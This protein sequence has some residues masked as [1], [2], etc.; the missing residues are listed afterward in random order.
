M[1][2]LDI[3][4]AASSDDC[5]AYDPGGY[6][7]LT[8]SFWLAYAFE[9]YQCDGAR[10][11]VVNIPQ[12]ATIIEAHVTGSAGGADGS[13]DPTCR[14]KAQAADNAATFSTRLD[15]DGR[16]RTTAYV[17][18]VIPPL[19]PGVDYDTPDLASLIQEVVARPGWMA[20]NGL[21]LFFDDQTLASYRVVQSYDDGPPHPPILHIEYLPPSLIVDPVSE[22]LLALLKADVPLVGALASPE[23]I[24][25]AEWRGT[26]F[27]YPAVRVDVTDRR[28]E[29]TG[30]C[31][32]AWLGVTGRLIAYSKEDSSAECLVLLGLLQNAIQRRRL[33][34]VGLTSLDL[35]VVQTVY[36]F[37]EL[38]LWRG[39]VIFATTAIET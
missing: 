11:A 22:A 13:P 24:K 23:C 28:P 35:K 17:D 6:L 4:V 33:A 38:N 5:D 1:P 19:T 21:V 26:D 8:S 15:F 30:A 29:G 7:N 34:L 9:T 14:I 31:A 37:R 32:E 12:G 16:S 25:E 27:D 39:E 2:T 18:W 36:P 3:P 20:G 10:F